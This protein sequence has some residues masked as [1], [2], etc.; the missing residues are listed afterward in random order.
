MVDVLDLYMEN[1][2]EGKNDNLTPIVLPSKKN[3]VRSAK[4]LISTRRKVGYTKAHKRM[5]MLASVGHYTPSPSDHMVVM[6]ML[7][8]HQL[9][10]KDNLSKFHISDKR[11]MDS[12]RYKLAEVCANL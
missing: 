4:E 9:P 2:D 6:G 7:R 11:R 10:M 12:A 3:K 1:F 5:S 8:S